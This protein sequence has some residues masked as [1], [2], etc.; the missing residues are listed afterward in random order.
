MK[1]W[2]MQEPQRRYFFSALTEIECHVCELFRQAFTLVFSL[3][4]SASPPDSP[5]DFDNSIILARCVPPTSVR[6]GSRHELHILKAESITFSWICWQRTASEIYVIALGKTNK[7]ALYFH[8]QWLHL[9]GDVMM[10]YPLIQYIRER[11]SRASE[12][13]YL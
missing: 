12:S 13:R 4:C 8:K 10:L 9:T 6:L 2:R 1:S 3:R 7:Q 5:G 11:L